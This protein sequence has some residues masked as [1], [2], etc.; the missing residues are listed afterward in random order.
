MLNGMD[1]PKRIL[2][3]LI[4]LLT[5]LIKMYATHVRAG[6][7]TA[8][9]DTTGGNRNSLRYIFIFKLYRD[10]EGVLQQSVT[11]NFGDGTS[12]EPVTD[13][14]T[15]QLGN[16][17]EELTFRFAHT[18]TAPGIYTV[19]TR[20]EMRNAGIVNLASPS[21]Q[22]PFYVET[23]LFINQSVGINNTPT[24]LNPPIDLGRVGQP[25]VHNPDAFDI[26][27]DSLA[28]RLTVPRQAVNIEA[29]GYTS[30]I[31]VLLGGRSE[32]GGPAT[33]TIDQEGTLTWDSPNLPG[34]YNIAF[35]IEEWRGGVKI[36]EVVRDMQIIVRDNPNRRPL[37]EV[38]NDT[39]IVAGSF[40]QGR[41]RATDTD[42][43]QN[44][45]KS[46]TRFIQ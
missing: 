7:I 6:E 13:R 4:F 46:P 12:S 22:I 45:K 32:A 21:D 40:L 34:E 30:R 15:R 37:L 1:L 23:T 33:L 17:T 41:V 2:L 9:R 26:D 39:C 38:P 44:E 43:E 11:L 16:A 20:I 19:S 25:F 28:Y 18:Y 35:V 14:I 29:N 8:I 24:L 27:G 31:P 10:T 42:G 3:I 5:P 36:G